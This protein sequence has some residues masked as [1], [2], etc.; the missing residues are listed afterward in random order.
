MV[1]QSFWFVSA[2]QIVDVACGYGFTALAVSDKEKYKL[3]GCGINTDSQ[4]GTYRVQDDCLSHNPAFLKL[5][6]SG[7]HF[8]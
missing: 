1:S 2:T 5:F 3:F 4:L 7:D 8:H 6:S